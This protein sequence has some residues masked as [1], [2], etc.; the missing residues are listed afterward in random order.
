MMGEAHRWKVVSSVARGP[1]TVRSCCSI[2]DRS[3]TMTGHGKAPTFAQ[4]QQRNKNPP[5]SPLPRPHKTKTEK[6]LFSPSQ[7]GARPTPTSTF[8]QRSAAE[9]THEEAVIPPHLN[10]HS[11]HDGLVHRGRLRHLQTLAVQVRA[12]ALD[13][14]IQLVRERVVDHRDDGLQHRD[15]EEAPH[16]GQRQRFNYSKI[17]LILYFPK[18]NVERAKWRRGDRVHDTGRRR[19]KET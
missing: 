17:L 7:G 12:A 6:R 1:L 19:G 15:E 10:L 16:E 9:Q 8:F 2:A 4:R 11:H 18:K 13:G 3:K 5:L 14:L